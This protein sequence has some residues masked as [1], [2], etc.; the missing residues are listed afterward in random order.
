MGLNISGAN[1]W[2][3][4]TLIIFWEIETRSR[5]WC[6]DFIGK[7][8]KAVIVWEKALHIFPKWWSDEPDV[9]FWQELDLVVDDAVYFSYSLE[10]FLA[11]HNSSIGDL[12]PC[13]VLCLLCLTPLTI[14][15]FTTLQSEPRDLWPLR[16]LISVMRRHDLSTFFV[17]FF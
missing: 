9:R 6:V 14:R 7:K 16:H 15:V 4:L 12:V 3:T 2:T 1:R 11:V 5:R 10:Y 8:H 17:D 13:L